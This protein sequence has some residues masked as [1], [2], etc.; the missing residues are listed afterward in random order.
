MY[1]FPPSRFR[2]HA[3]FDAADLAAQ[4]LIDVVL[5]A[6]PAAVPLLPDWTAAESRH[7]MI[8]SVD[9]STTTMEVP[10]LIHVGKYGGRS[11]RGSYLPAAC[12]LAVIP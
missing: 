1:F 4:A 9:R 2:H 12:C 6:V 11:F 3:V 8:D 5:V 7:K 10:T